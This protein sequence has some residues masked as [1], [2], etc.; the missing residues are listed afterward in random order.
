VT[1]ESLPQPLQRLEWISK[2][3]PFPFPSCL[4]RINNFCIS[5]LPI[6]GKVVPDERENPQ[7]T[8]QQQVLSEQPCDAFKISAIQTIPGVTRSSLLQ[9][10]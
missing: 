3:F 8:Y 6:L 7:K 5:F 1:L 4:P 2:D 9:I 10:I